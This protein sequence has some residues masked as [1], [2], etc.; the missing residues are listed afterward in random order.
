M[1]AC[2]FE[3]SQFAAFQSSAASLHVYV[4]RLC[5]NSLW[6]FLQ[7]LVN[8]IEYFNNFAQFSSLEYSTKQVGTL[9]KSQ[10]KNQLQICFTSKVTFGLD[11]NPSSWIT[12]VLQIVDHSNYIPVLKGKDRTELYTGYNLRNLH[13]SPL[14]FESVL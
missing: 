8:R 9:Q 4:K 5:R 2:T 1:E 7:P 6:S 11:S 10:A 13:L 14:Q 3:T 12:A